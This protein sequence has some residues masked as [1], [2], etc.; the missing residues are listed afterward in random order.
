MENKKRKRSHDTKKVEEYEEDKI[1]SSD[2]NNEEYAEEE[3]EIP[4]SSKHTKPKANNTK[5]T[6]TLSST[7]SSSSNNKGTPSSIFCSGLPYDAKESDIR[8]F[9]KECGEILSLRAPT[10]HDSGRLRGYAHIDFATA[11]GAN[12]A[13][14]KDGKYLND[15]FITVE[16]A[17]NKQQHSAP[18]APR[19]STC[20]T[21]YVKGLPYDAEESDVKYAFSR[22]GHVV[23]VR[24]ARWS[25]THNSKGFG[26][27]QYEHGYSA[28]AVMKHY[29]ESIEN[30]KDFI[31]VKNRPISQL[32]W[33][34]GAP[35]ASFRTADKQYFNKTEEGKS[36]SQNKKKSTS[37][38][39]FSNSSSLTKKQMDKQL[40]RDAGIG[41]Y[42]SNITSLSS[43]K[44]HDKKSNKKEKRSKHHEDNDE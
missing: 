3:Q 28:D 17:N 11:E 6:T 16:I 8:L 1:N 33:D 24:I 37:T 21:V 34:T 20:T 25:N 10:Y 2:D 12:K 22:F 18:S 26:Y 38:S 35:K 29:R 5:H 39:L 41:S 42:N 43:S 31:L 44:D 13:L 23:S 4:S 36:L 9:F 14:A 19:P 15:R 32:D 7:S 27:V 40:Y 30:N